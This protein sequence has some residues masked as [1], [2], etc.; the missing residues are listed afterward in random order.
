V[1]YVDQCE[2]CGLDFEYGDNYQGWM[3]CKCGGYAYAFCRDDGGRKGCGH[4][5]YD[6]PMQGD[7][8]KR[9]SFGYEGTS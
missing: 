5:T 9:V 8:C 7:T 3:I 4:T 6:P 1:S 2:Q